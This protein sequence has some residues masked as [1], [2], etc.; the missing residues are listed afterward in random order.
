MPQEAEARCGVSQA[1]A[2]AAVDEVNLYERLG[3]E[4]LL[5]VSAAFYDRVY[6]DTHRLSSTGETIRGVFANTTRAQAV[7]NQ[8]MYLTERLGGPKVYTEQKGS[9]QLIGRHAPYAGVD[10]EAAGRWLCLMAEALQSVGE[11]DGDSRE[12]LLRFFRYHA[13]YIVLGKQLVNCAR[14]VGYGGSRHH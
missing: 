6:S 4:T 5:R 10:E 12:R 3:S 9:F 14:L 8:H 2:V 11:V 13:Y 7:E 1:E